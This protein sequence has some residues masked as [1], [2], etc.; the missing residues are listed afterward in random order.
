MEKNAEQIIASFTVL[1]EILNMQQKAR[2]KR[3]RNMMKRM[4]IKLR[5]LCL[6]QRNE[7]FVQWSQM[8]DPISPTLTLDGIQYRRRMWTKKRSNDFWQRIV[9]E[10]FTLS[11]WL[12]TFRMSKET[13][14][15]LCDIIRTVLEPKPLFLVSRQPLSVEKQV[16]I[17]LYKLASCAEYRVVGDVMGVH[18]S[19]VRKCLFRVTMAINNVMVQENIF[20]PSE[21]EAQFISLQFKKRSFIPQLIG[22]IDGTHIPITAP[23]EGYRDFVNRK[24]WTS[25]NVM[26]VV[27]HNGR[28]RNVVIKHPGSVHDA[29]VFK[30]SSI[31]KNAQTIIPQTSKNID[32]VDIPYM[33]VGDPAYPMLSWLIK[34]YSG[35]LSA[36]EES[37]NVY[38]NSARVSVEMAFGRLKARWRILC[39][40]MDCAYTF[41]PQIILACCTLHNFVESHKERF[42]PE[43]L[44]EVSN[45]DQ[46]FPQPIAVQNRN[47]DCVPGIAV[48][49]HLKQYLAASYPLRKA[50]IR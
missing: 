3:L 34:G 19:T 42:F 50:L 4:R 37:F 36:E 14:T 31:Y 48:R 18:K 15:M 39:K 1:L 10:H 8:T 32:G 38:L 27:D 35:T 6:Q 49:N 16:A 43:W 45:S 26:A 28:F 24:G 41:C 30:D 40:K 5:K 33:I 23:H 17:A 13:F 11:E 7:L 21:D 47:R 20:M 9:G 25:Y 44:D 22:C 2:K 46:L 12:A 29:A